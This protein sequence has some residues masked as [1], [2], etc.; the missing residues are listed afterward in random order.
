MRSSAGVGTTPP[1]VLGAP[2]PLS[3]V[4]ISS[5]LGAPFGGTTRGAH[6]A[7]DSEA[8]SLITPPNFGSGGGSC[9]PLIVVV[10]LGEPGTPV[11]CISVARHEA[12]AN[13]SAAPQSTDRMTGVAAFI[14]FSFGCMDEHRGWV[15]PSHRGH[16]PDQSVRARR[17]RLWRDPEPM[18]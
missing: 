10:A 13:T 8:F 18:G 15:L 5:T 16:A 3:S 2:K 11:V 6:Q 4:M 1:K 12:A 17:P 14:G 9:L 7:F